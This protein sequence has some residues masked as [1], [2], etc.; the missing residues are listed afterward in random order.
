LAIRSFSRDGGGWFLVVNCRDMSTSVVPST[1]IKTVTPTAEQWERIMADTT[2]GRAMT[3]ALGRSTPLHNAGII[4][5]DGCRGIV[6]TAD[7]CPSRYG[8]DRPFFSSLTAYGNSINPGRP[9]S[10]A[11]SVSGLW[12][13][14]HPKDF[15]WLVALDDV[16]LLDITWV[17]HS[18]HHYAEKT[19]TLRGNYMLRPGTD[20]RGEVLNNERMMIEAG[21]VPSVFFRFPGLASDRK[22]FRKVADLGLI[23]LG[24]D[25]WLAKSQK[26]G[27]GSIVLVHANGNEP[28]GIRRFKLFLEEEGKKHSS[29]R[30]PVMDLRVEVGRWAVSGI[31]GVRPSSAAKTDNG[32]HNP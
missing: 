9:V 13:K 1:G 24:S 20:V 18:F 25:A 6:V 19:S 32:H 22:L 23:P 14:K 7:L 5:L 10:V 8:L 17:N 30:L 15:Q 3:R 12:L 26:A 29:D 27:R 28:D 16:N 2:Y 31:D 21:I 11:L 4:S